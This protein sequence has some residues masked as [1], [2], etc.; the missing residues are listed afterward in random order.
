MTKEFIMNE[1]PSNTVRFIFWISQHTHIYQGPFFIDVEWYDDAFHLQPN[2]TYLPVGHHLI[3]RKIT[4]YTFHTN[5]I[6][7]KVYQDGYKYGD[8]YQSELITSS[9][10]LE[11]H[12]F[13]PAINI[14]FYCIGG[15]FDADPNGD[16][17]PFHRVSIEENQHL[18]GA[19]HY[20]SYYDWNGTRNWETDEVSALISGPPLD[21]KLVSPDGNN[22][23]EILK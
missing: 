17:Y 7:T 22:V 18:L 12:D 3:A 9:D 1:L 10:V 23:I 13:D 6:G 2:E 21:C 4:G 15:S 14:K 5:A 20:N 11:I 19:W 16:I 8:W